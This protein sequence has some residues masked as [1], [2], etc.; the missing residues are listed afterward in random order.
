MAG[1]EAGEGLMALDGE[2]AAATP[3]A[4]G[5]RGGVPGRAGSCAELH[6]AAVQRV[7]ALGPREYVGVAVALRAAI[8][9][10]GIHELAQRIPASR[11][12]ARARRIGLPAAPAGSSVPGCAAGGMFTVTLSGWPH[13]GTAMPS[14]AAMPAAWMALNS[15]T[16]PGMKKHSI[17]PRIQGMPRPEEAAGRESPGRCG[18]DRSG[19]CRS[20]PETAPAECPRPRRG[21]P[22]RIAGRRWLAGWDTE[23]CSWPVLLAPRL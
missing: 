18:A 12:E 8:S 17:K 20:R 22:P 14:A 3:Q 7:H 11:A 13:P 21:A 4:D 15:R 10:A 6:Q 9:G 5:A 19:E 23:R 1:D 2:F 16:R